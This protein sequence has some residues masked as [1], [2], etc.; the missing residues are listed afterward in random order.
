MDHAEQVMRRQATESAFGFPRPRP[1]RISYL[2]PTKAILSYCPRLGRGRSERRLRARVEVAPAQGAIP[3]IL[4]FG[5]N[6]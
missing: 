6:E 5:T 3:G 2:I 1:A 4:R